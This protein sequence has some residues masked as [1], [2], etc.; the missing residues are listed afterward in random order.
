MFKKVK[1]WLFHQNV[2]IAQYF[3]IGR[4][5]KKIAKALRLIGY[6]KQQAHIM[7]IKTCLAYA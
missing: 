1:G 3:E 7:A 6:N 2:A 4:P 5:I